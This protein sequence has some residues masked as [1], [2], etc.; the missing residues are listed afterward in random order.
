MSF[1]KKILGL[2]SHKTQKKK[3][4]SANQ[5]KSTGTSCGSDGLYKDKFHYEHRKQ[6]N[7]REIYFSGKEINFKE[8][9]ICMVLLLNQSRKG[10]EIGRNDEYSKYY[11]GRYGIKNIN[12]LH[13]WLLDNGYLQSAT[14]DEVLGLYKVSELKDIL[15]NLGE[16]KTGK[17]TDLIDRI[18]N[19]LPDSEKDRISKS[20]K[21][22]FL[23]EKG[24]KFLE[25]NY[26]F[27]LFHRCQY[28][29]SIDEFFKNRIVGGQKR[30][31]NDTAFQVLSQRA[32]NYQVK[33]YFSQL[34]MI[35]HNLSNIC[36]EDG[37]KDLALQYEL[38]WMYFSSNLSTRTYLFDKE[39]VRLNKVENLKSR[40]DSPTIFNQY[41][42][43]RIIE[44]RGYFTERML[45]VVYAPEILPYSLFGKRDMLEAIQDL[46]GK[47][48]NAEKYT[49]LIRANYGNY[50]K[51]FL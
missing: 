49:N 48:F 5:K 13:R 39:F 32:Y 33:K 23:S 9:Q 31:F 50:I 11:E 51:K 20:C 46:Y 17:K 14:L 16:K 2:S 4:K 35:Y 15:E 26:D 37:K 42:L 12:K 25:E 10:C 36:Y 19:V 47:N 38:Y 29:I 40:I 8:V 18:K 24:E 7:Y 30:A 27:V 28:D 41:M 6:N 1:I 21:S 22:L 45:D 3:S 44:L 43:N 34:E